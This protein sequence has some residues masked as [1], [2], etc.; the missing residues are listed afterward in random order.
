MP[1]NE[2]SAVL[3]E[4]CRAPAPRFTVTAGREI[5]AGETLKVPGLQMQYS[6]TVNL[7]FGPRN[8]GVLTWPHITVATLVPTGAQVFT[9]R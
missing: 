3:P 2:L 8:P 6:Q 9:V 7:N 5:A 1:T 4:R